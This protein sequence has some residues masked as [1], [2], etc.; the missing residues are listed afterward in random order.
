[1][2]PQRVR[3]DTQHGGNMVSGTATL[4]FALPAQ[5]DIAPPLADRLFTFAWGAIQWPWLL[6]SLSPGRRLDRE[7]LLAELGLPADALPALGSWKADAGFLRLLAA[8][9]AE[10]RPKTV[11]EVGCGA[12]TLVL[13]QALARAGGGTLISHDQHEGFVAA[14]TAWLAD[15]GLAA[16]IRHAPLGPA[17]APWRGGWY[18]LG[19]LPPSIDLL[20]VDGPHWGVHPFA[21]GSAE[22][23]FERIPVGG[24]VMLDDGAR[25]G[26]RVVMARW[27]KRWPGFSFRLVHA[28]PKGTVIGHRLA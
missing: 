2:G 4:P 18:A 27:R 1:M 10:H 6:R 8:H 14:T 9:V 25:P 5:G 3:A 22:T 12:T 13:A 7:A 24:V 11:V 21:R 15:H 20:V 23:L 26:E 17:P 28:G 16:D 19:E